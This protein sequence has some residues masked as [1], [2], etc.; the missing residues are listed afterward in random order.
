MDIHSSGKVDVCML[1]FLYLD[2]SR[3][4]F[5]VEILYFFIE[6]LKL[7]TPNYQ[8]ISSYFGKGKESKELFLTK[9]GFC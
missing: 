8:D 9:Q 3:T 4:L 5:R 6:L 7:S 1:M 2:T